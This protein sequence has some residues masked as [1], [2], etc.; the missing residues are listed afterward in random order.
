MFRCFFLE[1][2]FLKPFAACQCVV[3]PSF[4]PSFTCFRYTSRS[5]GSSS[6]DCH[7]RIE[8]KSFRHS[9]GLNGVGS[10]R[11]VGFR[12]TNH[13]MLG[14]IFIAP[15]LRPEVQ[16]GWILTHLQG[17]WIYRIASCDFQARFAMSNGVFSRSLRTLQKWC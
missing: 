15:T 1:V 8:L 13:L 5:V 4:N 9:V 10:L 11:G 12:V 14:S 2:L 3:N 7:V 6:R 17:A 16:V